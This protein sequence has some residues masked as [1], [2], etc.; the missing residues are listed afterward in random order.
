MSSADV[1]PAAAH[2]IQALDHCRLCGG[3]LERVLDLGQQPACDHFPLVE[4]PRP[5]P[6]W[7]LALA[8]CLRCAL[9]QLDHASPPEEAALAVQSATMKRHAQEVTARLY[10][11]LELGTSPRVRE[12]SSHHGGSWIEAFTAAGALSVHER[13]DV[14]I[15]NQA[16]IHSEQPDAALARRVAALADDG[17]LVVEFHHA[18]RQL[19][20]AQFD[21][22]RHGHPLYF[23]LHSWAAA[24]A[25]HDLVVVDAWSE[26]VFGGCLIAVARRRGSPSAAVTRILEQERSAGATTPQ[27]YAQLGED[28]R[29]VCDDL[30][31]TLTEARRRGRTVAG[32]GA[33]S[34]SC[35]LL[36]VAGIGPDLLPFTADLSPAK[37][38]RRI[39]GAGIP[40]VAPEE[41]IRRAPETVVILTWDIAAEVIHQLR[42]GGLDAT[43]VIPQPT[44]RMVTP[45]QSV[46]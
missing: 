28:T 15:D 23:S 24:C 5:D 1:T 42:S 12:F 13:A 32:Y 40:I 11:R 44:L 45:G 39:P 9:V 4:A 38:G 27:G 17:V 10:R 25:R 20:E 3:A 31:A 34:K 2:P 8:M 36:G 16:I 33:G 37:H 21:T 22:V 26:E 46:D 30:V 14:V 35:T 19:R 6:T 7:P 29:R 18:A 43:F 41:L